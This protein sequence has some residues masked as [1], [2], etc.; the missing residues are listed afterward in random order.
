MQSKPIWNIC[1]IAIMAGLLSMGSTCRV[2]LTDASFPP[3]L[4]TV[5]IQEFVNNSNS[6]VPGMSQRFSQE[7]RDKF[8]D[9]T[10]LLQTRQDGDWEFSGTIITY[11]ITAIAPTGD[12]VT[13]LNRLTIAV[14][15][16]FE[17]RLSEE[18]SWT[19]T[20][21][22]YADFESTQ[23]LNDVEDGL[24]DDINNQLVQDIFNRVASNW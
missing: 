1:L 19:N 15:V 6:V 2:A 11:Q 12:D 7:L 22:R 21:S 17:N 10:N 8:N 18:E 24:I 23:A 16:E 14:N 20:F 13:A 4:E 9:E 3:E 5:T